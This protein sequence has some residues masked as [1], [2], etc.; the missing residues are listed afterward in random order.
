M[1]SHTESSLFNAMKRIKPQI[2]EK[3]C[4]KRTFSAQFFDGP[5]P[6]VICLHGF[7]D[8]VNTFRLLVPSLVEAGYRVV[9]PVMPGYEVGSESPQGHYFV[10][11]LAQELVSWMDFIGEERAH[12]IGHDWGAVTAWVAASMFPDRFFSLTSLAIP[13]LKHLVRGMR[14]HPGQLFKSWYM[15]FFQ[16]PNVPEWALTR[17]DGWFVRLLWRQ[18]SPG[19]R[20]PAD[21]LESASAVCTEQATR[22][23]VLG[24]YRCLFRILNPQNQ[25]A[26][27]ALK[28]TIKV[29]SLMIT[30]N[31]DGCM[32]SRLFEAAMVETDFPKGVEL[33]RVMGA[34]HFCHLE[35]PGLVNA[36]I[37][38]FLELH[39]MGAKKLADELARQL[40]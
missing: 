30:G 31:K 32:D 4:E 12:V 25:R 8:T 19:W 24:Y 16:L 17:N 6:L 5:G 11:D 28:G 2:V 23:A 14:A 40:G 1:Y 18:W 27:K 35:K 21:L 10:T 22:Q 7:P 20:A 26:L 34:G 29:P 15:M 38:S 36:K 13:S 9:V 33:Y 3:V 37:L 39:P